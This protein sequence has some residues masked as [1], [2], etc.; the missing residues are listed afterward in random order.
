MSTVRPRRAHTVLDMDPVR[1]P[2]APGAGQRPPEL[3]GR[4]ARADGVRRRAGADRARPARALAWCSPACAGSARRCCS[5]SCG[6]R[7][8]AAAGAPARSRPGPTS[9]CAARSPR[10]CTWPSASSARGT[11]D[12]ERVDEVL[13]VLK[14]FALREP[15][16]ASDAKL[17][18][19]WQ[20]GIDVPAAPAGPT[21]ATWRSTWSSCSPTPRRWPPTSAA[22]SPCSSTRCR[23]CSPTTCRP[24]A[25]P[26]TSCRSRA[27][28]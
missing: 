19:R 21:P 5:T 17:R 2:Y 22:G 1:N 26:A 27:R 8:S 28:R 23:T 9:R 6:R 4:D 15:D 16:D 12:Q 7:R 20:P 25:P 24:S 10:P 13:G 3:A 18:D 14:A 11:G